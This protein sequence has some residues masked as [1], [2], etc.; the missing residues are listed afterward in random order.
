MAVPHEEMSWLKEL[1]LWNI[2]LMS[3]T[4]EV[5]QRP[6][7]SLKLCKFLNSPL[8]FVIFETSQSPMSPYCLRRADLARIQEYRHL[9]IMPSNAQA[10]YHDHLMGE[11]L[12]LNP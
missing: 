3:I 4:E 8:A 5:F 11:R 10:A 9:A 7:S 12:T 1:A 6:M 2:E